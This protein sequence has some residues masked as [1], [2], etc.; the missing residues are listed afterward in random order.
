MRV[1]VKKWG[2]SLGVVLPKEIVQ[3]EGIR[4]SEVIEVKIERKPHVRELFGAFKFSK[5]TQEIKDEI[6]RGW[7]D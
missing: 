2:N 1:T 7:K 5:S 4:E 6:R 3:K